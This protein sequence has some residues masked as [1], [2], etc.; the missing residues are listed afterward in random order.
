MNPGK[1]KKSLAQWLEGEE[2]LVPTHSRSR[3]VL[4]AFLKIDRPV[5]RK[6]RPIPTEMPNPALHELWMREAA[7]APKPPEPQAQRSS[8]GHLRKSSRLRRIRASFEYSPVARP[9]AA[10][11]PVAA[12]N[13]SALRPKR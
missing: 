10:R 8:W 5:V 4:S 12:K 2:S 13:R 6:G 7:P 9:S 3:R 11:L 1:H